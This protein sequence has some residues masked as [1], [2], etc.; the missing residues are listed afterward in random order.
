MKYAKYISSF[1]IFLTT[2]FGIF[3][4]VVLQMKIGESIFL[5][6]FF[7]WGIVIVIE[8]IIL[9]LVLYFFYDAPIN[10]LEY[11]IKRFLVGS[12]KDEDIH[13]HKTTNPHLNY[14]LLFFTKTLGT[15]K[16]IKSEFLHGKEIKSEVD[17][18]WEIQ[19][20]LLWKKVPKVPKLQIVAKSTPAWEIGWDSY[21]VITQ[22]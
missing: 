19:W 16:N 21:D 3:S 8:F 12:L 1:L 22:W 6:W 14:I 15:L 9:K 2:C 11:T 7:I 17:L 10:K 5:L 20:K 13:L 18:A 4:M